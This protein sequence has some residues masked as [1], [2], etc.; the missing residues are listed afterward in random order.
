MT[1]LLSKIREYLRSVIDTTNFY[2]ALYDE[3]TDM[4]SLPYDVDEKDD[5]EIFPAGKTITKY[6]IESSKPLFAT[7]DV[8]RKL[9]KKD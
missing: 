6:V 2:V 3:K 7:K 4:I 9:I 1:E 8:V 5:Y